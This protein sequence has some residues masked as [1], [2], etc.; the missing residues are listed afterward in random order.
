MTHSQRFED[1]PIIKIAKIF[2]PIIIAL[3]SIFTFFSGMKSELDA[4][5]RQLS[6]NAADHKIYN[7]KITRLEEMSKMI[8]EIQQDVKE[9][10]RRSK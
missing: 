8:K 4:H 1:I 5:D 2:W 7:E 10:N 3:A 6:E 9:L